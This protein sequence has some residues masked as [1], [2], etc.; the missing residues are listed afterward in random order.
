MHVSPKS[1]QISPRLQGVTSHKTVTFLE[2]FHK[3]DS[4][5]YF[6]PHIAELQEDY[7]LSYLFTELSPS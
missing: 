5:I 6:R 7:L 2:C 3:E 4:A 1:R